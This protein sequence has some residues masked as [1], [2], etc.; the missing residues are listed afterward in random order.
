VR[1][2]VSGFRRM[3]I[4]P[5]VMLL[6]VACSN[7]TPNST[8][9][10]V[11]SPSSGLDEQAA[12]RAALG[13][14]FVPSGLFPNTSGRLGCTIQGG[15]PAPGLR[16]AGT[17]ATSA[18]QDSTGVWTV[19][20]TEY[21]DARQFHYQGEPATGQLSH[22]WTVLVAKNGQVTF[23]GDRGNFPPQDVR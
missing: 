5:T 17:C 3:L 12:V 18:A 8:S 13:S 1:G 15:G 7:P 10:N 2:T 19:T 6:F 20:F 14:S 16:L 9:H 22:S 21:W 23:A 11:G 4:L